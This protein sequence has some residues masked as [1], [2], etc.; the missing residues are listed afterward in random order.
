MKHGERRDKQ[1]RTEE[2]SLQMDEATDSLTSFHFL[3]DLLSDVKREKLAARLTRVFLFS[4]V[5]VNKPSHWIS[6]WASSL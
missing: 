3:S 4:T 5:M 6:Q 1:H 2:S